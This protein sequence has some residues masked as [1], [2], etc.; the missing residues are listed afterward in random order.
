M[1]YFQIALGLCRL[2]EQPRFQ[3]LGG[4][5]SLP[6]ERGQYDVNGTAEKLAEFD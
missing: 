4:G 3:V 2:I 1:D 5:A 6:S